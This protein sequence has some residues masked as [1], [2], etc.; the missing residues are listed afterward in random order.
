MLVIS[1]LNDICIKNTLSLKNLKIL[2]PKFQNVD[3]SII[4]SFANLA[5]ALNVTFLKICSLQFFSVGSIA[6][7]VNKCARLVAANFWTPLYNT[8]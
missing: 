2:R 1:I 8:I 3:N 5:P 7:L 4:I 6:A